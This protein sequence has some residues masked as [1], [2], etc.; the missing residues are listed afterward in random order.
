MVVF[1]AFV[2]VTVATFSSSSVMVAMFMMLILIMLFHHRLFFVGF[3]PVAKLRGLFCNLIA[4]LQWL[5]LL[6]QYNNEIRSRHQLR[7]N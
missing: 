2:F 6:V 5:V 4:K 1:V 7:I 3:K